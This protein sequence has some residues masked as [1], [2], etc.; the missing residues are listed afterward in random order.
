[1]SDKSEP[2]LPDSCAAEKARKLIEACETELRR[3]IPAAIPPDPRFTRHYPFD[4]ALRELIPN[5]PHLDRRRKA[6]RRLLMADYNQR[7]DSFGWDPK[8]RRLTFDDNANSRP[9]PE[10]LIE[11]EVRRYTENGFTADEMNRLWDLR[12]SQTA[13]PNEIQA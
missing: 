7:P 12:Q 5:Q 11:M 1:M 13:E 6:F 8:F 10:T 2:E 9:D 3:E 4:D